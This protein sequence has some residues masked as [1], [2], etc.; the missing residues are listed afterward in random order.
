[1]SNHIHLAAIAGRQALDSWL[2]PGHAPF[3]DMLN[4]A[5]QRIGPVFVRGA[6]V[7]V[8]RSHGPLQLNDRELLARTELR[9][10]PREPGRARAARVRVAARMRRCGLVRTSRSTARGTGNRAGRVVHERDLGTAADDAVAACFSVHD[11]H[12]VR[13]AQTLQKFAAWQRRH[14]T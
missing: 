6:P 10:D 2:R 7:E 8:E 12:G 13:T 3:A 1:M 5:H 4:E 9:G 14:V 11:A